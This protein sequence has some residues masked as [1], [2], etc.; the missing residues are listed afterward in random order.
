MIRGNPETPGAKVP[1]R[2]LAVLGGDRSPFQHGSGRLE[3]ARAIAS[4]DNPLTARVMVN[5]IWQ[6]HF[7][8]GLVATS[9]N[10]GTLGNGQLIPS[11]STGWLTGSLRPAGRSKALHRE[12]MLSAVYQQSSRIDS[13][14]F[15]KDPATPRCGG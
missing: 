4:A 13:P 12:I 11:C 10:F 3:L 1:R 6:H 9:S 5:R 8:R 15:A 2:F 14:G 7:G